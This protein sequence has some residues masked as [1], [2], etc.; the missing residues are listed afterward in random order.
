MGKEIISMLG[1]KKNSPY[2]NRSKIKIDSNHITTDDMANPII[3]LGDGGESAIL[4]PDT[5]DYLFPKS[6]YVME[7]KLNK[8]GTINEVEILQ[9][10]LEQMPP[11]EQD[12]FVDTYS[13]MNPIER[14][15][16]LTK[17][18]S[19]GYVY[20]NGGM[21]PVEVEGGESA[22]LPTGELVKFEGPKHANGGIPTILPEE[23]RVFSEHLKAPQE[24]INAVLGSTSKRRKTMSY[25]D[26]SKKFPTKPYEKILN[27]PNA[28]EYERKHAEI[29]LAVNQASLDTIFDSQEFVK[30]AKNETSAAR[31]GMLVYQK[32]GKVPPFNPLDYIRNSDGQ[33]DD[34]G[35]E[36]LTQF[37]VV[38]TEPSP[39][40][41]T[42]V[43]LIPNAPPPQ[44]RTNNWPYPGD[45][46]PIKTNE[47]KKVEER[48]DNK[49]SREKNGGE[50][51]PEL[52]KPKEDPRVKYAPNGEYDMPIL[53]GETET[54][55][56]M[57]YKPEDAVEDNASPEP[58]VQSGPMSTFTQQ[59]KRKS[60]FGISP[61]LAGTAMDILLAMS[62]NIR[63]EGPIYRDLRKYPLFTRFV[64]FDDKE[65]GRNLSLAIQ[66]IQN[67]DMPEQVKQSRIA[68][69]NAQYK[70]YQGKIDFANNQRYQQK[71]DQDTAKLE[72]YQNANI[73]QAYRD[74][75]TYRQK[76]ARVEYL[77][78]QFKA[79]R[80]SRIVN[81]LRNYFDY[82]SDT[83]LQNQVYG[84]QYR[85]NPFTGR[86]DFT[87]GRQDPFKNIETQ[88]QQYAQ[89][90]RNVIPLG[91]S[92]ASMV[93]TPMGVAVVSADGKFVNFQ[94]YNKQ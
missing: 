65:V 10:M 39:T 45:F 6:N 56:T 11:E 33:V 69:L 51:K 46:D 8:G 24:V 25:A 27:D 72:A 81:S 71:I 57:F 67:S 60:K 23:T 26:L 59:V 44:G 17:M 68:D 78:D 64:D 14:T 28:D 3:A 79:Q 77:R 73:D 4:Y 19:G 89:D 85:I 30:G 91:D 34:R 82:V 93:M 88:M 20:Q 70:D 50:R 38:L 52:V 47:D 13:S 94:P 42:G 83:N 92:G 18:M 54:P 76:K 62:D 41:S 90:S 16:M 58:E 7:Y 48:K 75:D 66:Q 21:V 53:E 86:V 22:L 1:Y 87:G 74:I 31:D 9:S 36:Y 40:I 49:K 15:N 84:D 12:Q 55:A 80:K 61:K 63:T 2:K 29:K 37:P 32:A 35:L 43:A 5:G